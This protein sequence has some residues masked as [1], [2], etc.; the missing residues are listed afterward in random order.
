[1]GRPKKVRSEIKK[2]VRQ[3]PIQSVRGMNDILPSEQIYWDHCWQA[4]KELTEAYSFKRIEVPV[5]ERTELFTRGIGPSTD[6]VEKEMFTF[7]DKGG[8]SLTLRPEWTAGVVR[9]YIEHGMHTLPQPQKLYSY[10]PCFR[11][12]RPQAGRLRQFHQ[13]NLEIIGGKQPVLDA[14]IIFIIWEILKKIGLKNLEVQI[15][16]IGCSECRNNYKETLTDFLAKK[17]QKLCDSCK[18]RIRKNPL[19]VLDCKRE[20]CQNLVADAPQIID[21][22]CE[23]CHSH[24]KSVL[25]YLDEIEV[26]YNLNPRLV[27]GLDY[28]TRTAFE[29]WLSNDL[30]GQRS[31]GGGGRY[32]DLVELLGGHRTSA[33]GGAIGIER[34]IEAVKEQEIKIPEG[35]NP[36]VLFVQLGELAKK[37]S[38]RIF[39]DLIKNGIRAREVFHKDSIKT[40]L[41]I[42]NNLNVKIAVILGQKEVLDGTI[43][44]RDMVN[45]VQEVINI[46]KLIPVIKEKLKKLK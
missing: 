23:D 37:K 39:N 6:I 42:A 44:V 12:E 33:V 9:A 38:L 46:D 26:A 29:V 34:V 2:K 16:S 32:D 3:K 8:E 21:Y 17:R 10:G 35:K 27:R 30:T 24:F 1:M 11:H 5:L 7:Q 31:L 45:S 20:K 18:K 14:E 4:I 43:L 28:Y 25:E 22:L 15:N 19:R 41:K 40:Q 36:D 13:L